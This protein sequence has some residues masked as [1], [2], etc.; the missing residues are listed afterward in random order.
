[1]NFGRK[2]LI[3]TAEQS[4][5]RSFSNRLLFAWGW[6][7]GQ[8]GAADADVLPLQF[9]GGD[10]LGEEDAADPDV[11]AVQFLDQDD[12]LFSGDSGDLARRGGQLPDERCL[13]FPGDR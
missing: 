4:M 7:F 3:N 9:L 13:G 12:E 11:V 8:Q 5:V 10:Q 1:M 6:H 2:P